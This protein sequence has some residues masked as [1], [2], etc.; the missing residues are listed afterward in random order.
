MRHPD[1]SSSTRSYKKLSVILE[2][3][4]NKHNRI[5]HESGD[6][7]CEGR[8]KKEGGQRKVA[9]GRFFVVHDTGIQ[10][11]GEKKR[12]EGIDHKKVRVLNWKKCNSID[13]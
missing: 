3:N 12:E 5:Y 10:R 1:E 11:C 2:Q 8:S 13:K 7:G 4:T 9:A 6:F